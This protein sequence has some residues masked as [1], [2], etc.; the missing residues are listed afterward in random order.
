MPEREGRTESRRYRLEGRV[1]GVGFR[2]FVRERARELGL[3]GWTRNEPDG[4][5][6]VV[7]SGEPEVLARFEELLRQGP[8]AGRVDRLESRE[9]DAAPVVDG[10]EVRF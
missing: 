1:Q 5:V 2:W 6:T 3:H 10:F 9:A 8:P 4:S 7:A